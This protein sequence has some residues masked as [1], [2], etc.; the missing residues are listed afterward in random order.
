[1]LN[2]SIRCCSFYFPHLLFPSYMKTKIA[3]H[4]GKRSWHIFKFNL[5]VLILFDLLNYFRKK[6]LDWRRFC[7]IFKLFKCQN[8][9][10]ITIRQLVKLLQRFFIY[11]NIIFFKHLFHLVQVYSFRI[12][13][14]YNIKYFL[15]TNLLFKL[16]RCVQIWLFNLLILI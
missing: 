14:I 10:I 12:I 9:W 8:I 15:K 1:M 3:Y 13:Y 6:L 2:S 16:L 4:R 11:I 7:Y 5:F